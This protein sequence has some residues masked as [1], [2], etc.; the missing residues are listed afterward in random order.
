MVMRAQQMDFLVYYCNVHHHVLIM[1][2]W[3]TLPI[4]CFIFCAHGIRLRQAW[5][6]DDS[7][8]HWAW[9][10]IHLFQL[11]K[12]RINCVVY[13]FSM[14]LEG[15]FSKCPI[16]NYPE[17]KGDKIV[18]FFTYFIYLYLHSRITKQLWHHFSGAFFMHLWWARCWWCRRGQWNHVKW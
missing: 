2:Q 7:W 18:A 12:I 8:M 5:K 17:K 10:S 6:R 4:T 14:N 15:G 13:K 16:A 1:T 9:W 11:R 3:R